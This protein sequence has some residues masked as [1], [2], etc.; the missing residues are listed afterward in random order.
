MRV[1]KIVCK[2]MTLLLAG[3]ALL[4]P[5]A[6][7]LSRELDRLKPKVTADEESDE[8]SRCI[9]RVRVS[10]IGSPQEGDRLVVSPQLVQGAREVDPLPGPGQCA[11]GQRSG[12][13]QGQP[14]FSR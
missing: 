10:L 7:R 8:P 14:R 5:Q 9:V 13:R 6:D 11:S 4:W 3:V 1:C 12:W 2:M